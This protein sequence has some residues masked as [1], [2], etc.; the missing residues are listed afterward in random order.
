M[1]NE[2]ISTIT[3]IYSD[4]ERALDSL[5]AEAGK[6]PQTTERRDVISMLQSHGAV[7]QTLEKVD[8]LRAK[9]LGFPVTWGVV[10]TYFV[11]MFTLGVGLWSVLRGVGVGFSLQFCCPAK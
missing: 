9:L 5:I 6:L 4:T 7:L 3:A 1:A 11:T 8:R 10:K 2:Q